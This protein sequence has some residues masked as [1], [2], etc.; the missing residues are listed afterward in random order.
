ME[1]MET[2]VEEIFAVMEQLQLQQPMHMEAL[3]LQMLFL[4]DKIRTPIETT[5]LT[6]KS[7]RLAKMLAW[8]AQ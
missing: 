1:V 7:R 2:D 6:Y 5:P 3:H 8:V 4:V